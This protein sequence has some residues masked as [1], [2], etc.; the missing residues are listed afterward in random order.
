MVVT[1]VSGAWQGH[2]NSTE[3][4]PRPS[5]L[6]QTERQKGEREKKRERERAEAELVCDW[7]S[8]VLSSR[9]YSGTQPRGQRALTRAAALPIVP[10]TGLTAG[11]GLLGQPV[12]WT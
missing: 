9:G 6:N 8:K 5:L 2:H 4:S 3:V 7:E 12:T 11:A 10:R 1:G